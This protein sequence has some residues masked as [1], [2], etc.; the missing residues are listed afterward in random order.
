MRLKK[1]GIIGPNENM[2]TRELYEFG[3]QLGQRIATDNRI[4]ICGGL[5]GFMEAV[6]KGIKQSA[7][8]F[9]GQTIGILPDDTAD[10]ANP[11]IDVA[12]PTGMGIARNIIIVRTVDILI[13]A[14]GGS[15]TL[16]ELAFAWQLGKKT[17][18][19]TLFEGWAREMAG[20]RVDPRHD[21]LLIPVNSIEEIQKHLDR[22]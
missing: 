12:I 15:G 4:F 5:G 9:N 3:E 11:Y 19:V 13:A 22:E 18:C 7:H 8:T 1:I 10:T 17:L 2:C 20:I 16:S 21:S 14:G 6:C